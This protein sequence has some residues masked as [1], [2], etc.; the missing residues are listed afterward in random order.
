MERSEAGQLLYDYCD[1]LSLLELRVANLFSES[2]DYLSLRHLGN[3]EK[4]KTLGK[5]PEWQKNF[6]I[7]RD[8]MQRLG[9]LMDEI[10]MA[11]EGGRKLST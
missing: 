1:A 5:S 9:E 3:D 7:V 8:E 6:L 4:V 10:V 2:T 11:A